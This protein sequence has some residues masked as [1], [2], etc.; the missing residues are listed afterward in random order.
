MNCPTLLFKLLLLKYIRL[1]FH[2]GLNIPKRPTYIFSPIYHTD[3]TY[4]PLAAAT[5]FFSSL[6]QRVFQ[7]C[8]ASIRVKL[9][10]KDP[11]Q[12]SASEKDIEVRKWRPRSPE[13]LNRSDHKNLS[14][15]LHTISC[16]PI[17]LYI[18]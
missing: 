14:L 5:P 1:I 9:K 2:A 12:L 13:P 18:Q 6:E 10:K 15:L 3:H 7:Q 11:R 8:A 4:L 16:V 17:L